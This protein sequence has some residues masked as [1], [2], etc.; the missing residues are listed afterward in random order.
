MDN[1]ENLRRISEM[2]LVGNQR[3]ISCKSL[4]ELHDDEVKK[5]RR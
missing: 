5:L 2:P 1:F 3:L 4:G